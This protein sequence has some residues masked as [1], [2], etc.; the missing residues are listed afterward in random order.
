MVNGYEALWNAC[1]YLYGPNDLDKHVPALQAHVATTSKRIKANAAKK[2]A[3][4][5]AEAK[6]PV[7]TT[8]AQPDATTTPK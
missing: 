7:A 1:A 6:K 8:P 3:K 4:L 5:A 2:A